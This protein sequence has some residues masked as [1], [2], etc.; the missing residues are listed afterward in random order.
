M[1]YRV[2]KAFSFALTLSYLG[3][4]TIVSAAGNDALNPLNISTLDELVVLILQAVITVGVPLLVFFFLLTGF[5]FVTARGSDKGTEYA[6]TMLWNTLYGAALILGA[7]VILEV[8][9]A[10]LSKLQI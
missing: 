5:Y 9:K 8:L 1:K 4:A 3:H 2:K 7:K 6:K 10:T